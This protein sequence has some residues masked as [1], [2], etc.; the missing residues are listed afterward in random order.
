VPV[1]N[2]ALD[3]V[4]GIDGTSVP[5]QFPAAAETVQR[6]RNEQ[7]VKDQ[8]ALSKAVIPTGPSK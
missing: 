5:R 1:R 2:P 4:R 7:A 3:A 6:A 8:D